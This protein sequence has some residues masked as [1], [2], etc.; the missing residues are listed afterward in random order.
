M[1]FPGKEKK[2]TQDFPKTFYDASQFY[3][4]WKEAWKK[5]KSIFNAHSKFIQIDENKTQ[6]IDNFSDWKIAEIKYL[7]K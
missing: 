6:D 7:N 2:R 4:G 5:H 3:L 1:I